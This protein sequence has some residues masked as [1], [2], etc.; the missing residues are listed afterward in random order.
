MIFVMAFSESFI[1]T[2][3]NHICTGEDCQICVVI[4]ISQDVLKT[5]G[6]AAALIAAISFLIGIYILSF[7]LG[8]I[9]EKKS[10]T[11]YSLKVKLNN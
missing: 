9:N 2:H 8:S 1:V 4:R 7:L 11:L 6:S 5:I 3:K 10:V